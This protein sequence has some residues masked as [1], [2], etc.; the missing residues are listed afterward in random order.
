MD[1]QVWEHLPDHEEIL[2]LVLARLPWWSNARLRAVSKL[3]NATLSEPPFLTWASMLADASFYT[4]HPN[5]TW[6]HRKRSPSQTRSTPSHPRPVCLLSTS[7]TRCAVA[8]FSSSRWS[9]LPALSTLPFG[10]WDEFTVTAAA[11]GLVLLERNIEHHDTHHDLYTLDR[12]LFNPANSSWRKLPP[13]PKTESTYGRTYSVLRQPLIMAS[14]K[15][16]SVRVVA[17]EFM[18]VGSRAGLTGRELQRIYTYRLAQGAVWELSVS[19]DARFHQ[20]RTVESVVFSDDVYIHSRY[21]EDGSPGHRL[22][23]TSQLEDFEVDT[24][25]LFQYASVPI[26]HF[27]QHRGQLMFALGTRKNGRTPQ[28]QRIRLG[29]FDHR[30]GRW[31]KEVDDM[32]HAMVQSL[33][34]TLADEGVWR[35]YF[36]V[37]GDFLCFGN[38]MK[39]ELFVFY[40]LCTSRWSSSSARVYDGQ[41]DSEQSVFA[42]Q[43]RTDFVL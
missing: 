30:H 6:T 28:R 32:P 25:F 39:A 17:M 42:W 12:F 27:F 43:P 29:R 35:I 38:Q 14:D 18:L 11:E 26:L 5:L 34:R 37:E 16:R 9:L 21:R 15:D 22:F 20:I 19:D 8:N 1:P 13:V 36:D 40:N 41:N 4:N 7:E 23:R 31:H 2:R 33:Y 10:R 3:W 24:D